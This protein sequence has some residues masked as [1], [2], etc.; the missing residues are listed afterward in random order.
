LEGN[1]RYEH[2]PSIL[3][4]EWKA[5]IDDAKEKVLKNQENK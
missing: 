1:T 2:P 4:R 3:E 5:I